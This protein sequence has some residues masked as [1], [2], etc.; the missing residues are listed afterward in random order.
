MAGRTKVPGRAKAVA[1][2]LAAVMTGV[3]IAGAMTTTTAA[4]AEAARCCHITIPSNY[5]YNPSTTHQKTLHDYCSYSPDEFPAPGTNANFRGACARHDMCY[6][7]HQKSQ[8]GCD[9]QLGSQLTQECTYTYGTFDPRR[10]ACKKTAAVYWAV[11]VV[12]TIWP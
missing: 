11:V 3:F 9:N 4:P 8:L 7:Y 1:L 10:G 12:H 2:V 5:V 6:Q